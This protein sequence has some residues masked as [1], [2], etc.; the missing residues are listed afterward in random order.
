MTNTLATQFTRARTVSTPLVAIT[1]ADPGAAA[2]LVAETV[3]DGVVLTWD[4]VSGLRAYGDSSEGVAVVRGFGFDHPEQSREP[5]LVLSRAQSKLPPDGVLI[6]SNMHRVIADLGTPAV[7]A[8]WNLRDFFK[9][10]R[11]ML[12][13]V[14][15]TFV[16]PPELAHDVFILD[17]PLPTETELRGIVLK[18]FSNANLPEPSEEETTRAVEAVTG[19][20]QFPAEQVIAM[21]L[22]RSGIDLDGAWERKR[23][24]IE[25]TPGLRIWRGHE[26]MDDLKG[27]DNVV[28]FMKRMIAADVFRAIVFIDEMDKAFAGGM[29]E[30]TGDSGVAKDQVGTVLSYIEDT[31]SPGVMLAGVAGTGKTQLVKAMGYTSG[32]P[33]IVFDLGGMKGGVVGQSEA[34]IRNA[35]KVVTAVAGGRVLFVGT[36]NKTT[37]F[38]PEMMRRFPDQFFFDL[39]DQIGRSAIWPVYIKKYGLTPEQAKLPPNFAEDWTG[40]EIKRACQRAATFKCSVVEASQYIVPTAVN[41]REA[42]RRM[43]EEAA[44]RFLSASYPGWYQPPTAETPAAKVPAKGSG[45]RR[46]DLN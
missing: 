7:Q 36:A 5:I 6:M 23:R 11:R 29:S 38:S 10:N 9:L 1:T 44:G 37:H 41:G 31:E 28:S 24:Q 22:R 16:P 45:H 39:P 32:K 43:R 14:G 13:M 8:I 12:V 27:I 30:H 20:S 3:T 34:T 17:D 15:A 40:A 25:L 19:L 33:V 2:D 46:I 18:T 35:L 26:S 42:I 4:L 21:S